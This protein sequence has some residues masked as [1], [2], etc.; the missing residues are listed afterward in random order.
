MNII[1]ECELDN[2]GHL[3]AGDYKHRP[4]QGFITKAQQHSKARIYI[5]C[6]TAKD[7]FTP[8]F[9]AGPPRQQA[10]SFFLGNDDFLYSTHALVRETDQ[11]QTE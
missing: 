7:Y 5:L 11:E 4:S 3:I 6:F 10:T 1:I 9:F 8:C 2:C